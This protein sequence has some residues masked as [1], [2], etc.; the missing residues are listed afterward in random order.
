MSVA[1]IWVSQVD[2]NVISNELRNVESNSEV[3]LWQS[4][5]RLGV[6]ILIGVTGFAA[7][8]FGMLGTDSVG[9]HGFGPRGALSLLGLVVAG[10]AAIVIGVVIHARRTRHAGPW[11]LALTIAADLGVVF[12]TVYLVTPVAAYE[13]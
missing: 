1:F 9:V 8:A 3:L 10:Y 2:P 4:R 13:R 12:G 11:I 5:Y 6:V 7:R